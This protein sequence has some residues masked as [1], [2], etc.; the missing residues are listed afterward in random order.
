MGLGVSGLG[1]DRASADGCP[2]PRW[3][4]ETDEFKRVYGIESVVWG[5]YF[6]VRSGLRLW[7]LLQGGVD[8]FLLVVLVTGP[9][10]MF[11][12]IVWSIHYAIRKLSD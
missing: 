3:F 5:L 9:P 8:S 12:L 11:L 7:A 10:A 1:R 2:F 6:L 4:R